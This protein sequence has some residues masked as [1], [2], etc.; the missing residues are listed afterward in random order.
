MRLGCFAA[1]FLL[2]S[3]AHCFSQDNPARF[4]EA[5]IIGLVVDEQGRP[6][7]NIFVHAFLKQKHLFMPTANSNEAGEF[8]IENLEAGTYDIFGENDAAGYPNTYL[9]FYPNENPIQ[10]TLGDVSTARVFL[11]LGPKAGV[12]SGEVRDKRSGRIIASRHAP[13]F[14]V[15]K[16]SNQE[17][18]IEFHGP[19]KFRWLIPPGT[20]VTLEVTAEGYKPWLY[21]YPPDSLNPLPFRLESGEEKIL[22]IEL[23]PETPSLDRLSSDVIDANRRPQ[24]RVTTIGN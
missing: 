20:D 9:P 17:D 12:L 19:P 2:L 13:R 4:A 22:N 15:R 7:K 11:A 10:V 16:S 5:R 8:A 21:A 18:S 1:V 23:E 3:I 6:L 14:I 24:F